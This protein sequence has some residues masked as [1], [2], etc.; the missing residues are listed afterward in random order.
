MN[1]RQQRVIHYPQPLQ[2]FRV[3]PQLFFEE[4]FLFRTEGELAV[5]GY[6]VEVFEDG[7][8][9]LSGAVFGVKTTDGGSLQERMV[10]Q[11]KGGKGAGE[12]RKA[13]EQRGEKGGEGER[14]LRSYVS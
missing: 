10:S 3:P 2:Q 6:P 9:V 13:E 1:P 5:A 7:V 12:K 8:R 14:T 4:G 11:R